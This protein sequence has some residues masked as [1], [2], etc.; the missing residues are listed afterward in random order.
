M[1]TLDLIV[2]WEINTVEKFTAPS[3]PLGPHQ[4]RSLS[5]GE[6]DKPSIQLFINATGFVLGG[7][8]HMVSSNTSGLRS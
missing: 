5:R 8:A 7:A 1:A 2:L 3:P 6:G 4:V